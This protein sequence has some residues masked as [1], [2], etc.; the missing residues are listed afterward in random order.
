MSEMADA[1]RR[2]AA[3]VCIPVIADVDTGYGGFA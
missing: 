1:M 3:R 2:M